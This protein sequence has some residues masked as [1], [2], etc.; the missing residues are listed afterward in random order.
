MIRD[1][2]LNQLAHYNKIGVGKTP[3]T[4]EQDVFD[5]RMEKLKIL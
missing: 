5:S 3:A 2:Y 1:R 4:F